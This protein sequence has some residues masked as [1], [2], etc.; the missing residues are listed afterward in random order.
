MP[1]MLQRLAISGGCATGLYEGRAGRAAP[2]QPG[3]SVAVPLQ[4]ATVG[5]K[6]GT[7]SMTSGGRTPLFHRSEL[8]LNFVS[9]NLTD[10]AG[11][12]SL[13]A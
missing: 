3:H 11:R 10:R 8:Q 13:G 9:I 7:F 4:D 6:Y 2:S 1:A 5:R 12:G